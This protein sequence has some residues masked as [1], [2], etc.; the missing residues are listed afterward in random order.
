[1]TFKCFLITVLWFLKM[2]LVALKYMKI[3]RYSSYIKQVWPPHHN[4]PVLF[5]RPC[6]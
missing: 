5:I 2:S 4:V 3:I 6:Y 1:M